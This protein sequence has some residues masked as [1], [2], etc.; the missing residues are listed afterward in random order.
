[1]N[2]P[3]PTIADETMPMS[4]ATFGS[5]RHGTKQQ[6]ELSGQGVETQYLWLRVAAQAA[7][8]E[9]QRMQIERAWGIDRVFDPCGQP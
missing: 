9:I 1:M 6:D 4:R 3:T 8:F 2:N 5:L 7:G